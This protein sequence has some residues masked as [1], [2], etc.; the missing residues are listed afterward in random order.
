MFGCIILTVLLTV[1]VKLEYLSFAVAV[2]R[3]EKA[4]K[5]LDP[6]QKAKFAEFL[7]EFAQKLQEPSKGTL[8]VLLLYN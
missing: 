2:K 1:V 4:A 3:V 5:Q 7:E 8:L 6:N